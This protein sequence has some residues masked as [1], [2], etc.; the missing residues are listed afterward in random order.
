[1]TRDC[2]TMG[3]TV[4]MIKIKAITAATGK[5]AGKLLIALKSV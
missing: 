2:N 3:G 5:F 4:E 1:M